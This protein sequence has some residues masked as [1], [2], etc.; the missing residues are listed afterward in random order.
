MRVMCCNYCKKYMGKLNQESFNFLDRIYEHIRFNFSISVIGFKY[1]QEYCNA[2][3][4]LYV[5]R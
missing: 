3:D 1:M 2:L 5:F 4:V